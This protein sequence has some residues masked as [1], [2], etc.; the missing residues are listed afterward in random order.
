[1]LDHTEYFHS[2]WIV[3]RLSAHI[4]STVSS[5]YIKVK[6]PWY[7][8]T[9]PVSL[10]VPTV[11]VIMLLYILLAWEDFCEFMV[12]LLDVQNGCYG[13]VTWCAEWLLRFGYLMCRTVVTVWLLDVRNGRYS[14]VTCC[15][16]WL[17]WFGYLM[18]RTVVMVWL[19]DVQNGWYGLVTWCAER[20]YLC[21]HGI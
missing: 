4:K 1:V 9:Y 7:M 11:R 14:L 16:E 20:L 18:C 5:L 21:K 13:L 17:L 15:A 8:M 2:L 12:W 3:V 6:H 19:L 10:N